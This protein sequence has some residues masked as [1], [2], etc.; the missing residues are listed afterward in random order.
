MK[1]LL[2]ILTVLSMLF[3]ALPALAESVLGAA[4]DALQA[5]SS[6]DD[7]LALL[8]DVSLECASELETGG[9]NVDLNFAPAEE[10]PQSLIP[11]TS[12]AEQADILPESLK[13]KKFIA[14]YDDAGRLSLLGDY[15]VRLPESM[16][17]KSLG[18][19]EA[20][21]YFRHYTTSR[22]DYTG[23]ASNRHYVAYVADLAGGVWEIFSK[24]TQPPV[25]G[26][27]SLSGETLSLMDLW[28]GVRK[29]FY[30]T[31][32]MTYPEG[33]A[34]FRVTGNSCSIVGLEGEFIHYDIPAEVE[35][36]PVTG[37]ERIQNDTLESLTLPE[38][39][40]Y[41]ENAERYALWCEKL[42][43]LNFPS[44]LRR[45]GTYADSHFPVT[46][47]DFNEGLEEIGD[48]TFCGGSS[49]TSLYL[50]SSLKRIGAG[51]LEH[52]AHVPVVIIPEGIT[53]LPRDVLMSSGWVM[54]AYIPASVSSFV[55][56]DLLACFREK[57]RIYTPEGSYAS[58]WAEARD[59]TWFPCESPE[60]MPAYGIGEEG[61]FIYGYLGDEA[62]LLE[63]TGD[64]EEVIVPDQLGGRPVAVIHTRAFFRNDRIRSIRLPESLTEI[65][66]TSFYECD[67]LENV[68]IPVCDLI[69]RKSPFTSNSMKTCVIHAPDGSAAH[70]W[71]VEKGMAW[72]AW[73][74]AN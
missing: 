16:R 74:P 61:D 19:A 64:A 51:F 23:P 33:T 29:V 11:D 41:I 43:S 34:T 37:I 3:C 73:S 32:V 48:F 9:W 66:Q 59:Y 20:V 45:I 15:Y 17:A 65:Q 14:I 67:S 72:E 54:A 56:E 39:I 50:P 47:L 62:H 38:G 6:I 52:G 24:M 18:E 28:S 5:A 44:T 7:Q 30:G 26:Y 70:E 53:R 10:I 25:S 27:G 36:Y 63:Y 40:V 35:G 13:D 22:S 69:I 57:M 4:A 31:L 2:A 49:I 21:L 12:D 71:A 46:A 55:G 60:E 58:R 1:K 8:Y 42:T 68:F